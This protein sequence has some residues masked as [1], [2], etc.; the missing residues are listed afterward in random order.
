MKGTDSP[1]AKNARGL[2]VPHHEAAVIGVGC[3]ALRALTID[4]GRSA[5]LRGRYQL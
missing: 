5:A 2:S 1:R 3:R 4:S